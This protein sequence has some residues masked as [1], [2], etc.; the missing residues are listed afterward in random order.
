MKNAARVVS[1]VALV[2]TILPPLLFFAD[3]IGLEAMKTWMLAATI[4]WFAA[5]PVWMDR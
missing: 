4:A 1:L 3:V 2:A 5:A